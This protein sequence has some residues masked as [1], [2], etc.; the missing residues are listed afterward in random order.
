MTVT[1]SNGYEPDFDIDIERGWVAEEELRAILGDLLHG[2]DRVEVKRDDRALDTQNVYLEYA[3]KPR[4]ANGYKSSGLKATKA[5]YL[6]VK[7]GNCLVLA[8]TPAWRWVGNEH[9]RK[10]ETTRGDNPTK[11]VAVSIRD[12]IRWL[13][14]APL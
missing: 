2:G 3:Q 9:G 12:L 4:G 1:R 10:V 7:I 8:P 13:S 14:K 5:E 6:C 11:G